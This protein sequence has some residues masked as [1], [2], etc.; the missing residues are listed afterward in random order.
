LTSEAKTKSERHHPPDL[1]QVT[2]CGELINPERRTLE[3]NWSLIFEDN[4]Q[5][6]NGRQQH[7]QKVDWS[8]MLVSVYNSQ[9][10]DVILSQ[11]WKKADLKAE[12]QIPSKCKSSAHKPFSFRNLHSV[13]SH[14]SNSPPLPTDPQ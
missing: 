4:G 9:H 11:Q 2:Q 8:S 1:E 10:S 3:S 14:S 12:N 6:L 7:E 5:E 13:H